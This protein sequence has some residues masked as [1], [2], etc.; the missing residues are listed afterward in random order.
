MKAAIAMGR[1]S[2]SFVQPGMR[3]LAP[4]VLVTASGPVSMQMLLP[5]LPHLQQDLGVDPATAQLTVSMAL[6]SFGMAM[7]AWGVVSD[8]YGRRIPLLVGTGLYLL[9]N[10]LCA[11]APDISVLIVGRVLNAIGGAAGMVAT[12]AMIRDVYPPDQVAAGISMLTVGQIVPPM[13]APALGGIVTD[14]FGWRA[15]FVALFALGLVVALLVGRLP[16]T[17]HDRTGSGSLRGLV[18]SFG[19]LLRR[20]RFNA[21]ALFSA[22]AISAYFAFL[23]G[24]PFVAQQI[25]GMSATTYGVLFITISLSYLV[26]NLGAAKLSRS[27]G[28]DRMVFVGGGLTVLGSLIGLGLAAGGVWTV[29][30]LFGPAALVAAGNGLS[31]NNAQAGAMA[32]NPRAAGAAAGLTGFMQMLAGGLMAQA[33]GLI[34]GSTPMPLWII[35]T[36]VSIL[37]LIVFATLR[38]SPPVPEKP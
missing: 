18:G 17:H 28:H 7:L 26:G 6:I 20:R 23:A 2:S 12:R 4:L 34:H 16:E 14:A 31:L 13:L 5:A 21:F 11:V 19:Q 22:G 35:L 33:V 10:I 29:A 27:L 38:G 36:G 32:V 24:A 3:F 8:R 15:N 1:S 30:A 9:G 37:G 25:L